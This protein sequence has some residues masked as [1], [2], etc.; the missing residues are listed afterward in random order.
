VH[1]LRGQ[2]DLVCRRACVEI[3]VDEWGGHWNGE[4]E[5]DVA[6]RRFWVC[7]ELL[8]DLWG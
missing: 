1:Q 6:G 5:S 2:N 8:F 7:V 3:R 4:R